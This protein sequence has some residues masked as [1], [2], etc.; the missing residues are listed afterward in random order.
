VLADGDFRAARLSTDLLD[1]RTASLAEDP[2][3]PLEALLAVAAADLLGVARDAAGRGSKDGA[4]PRSR[5]DPWTGLSG[6]R[7]TDEGVVP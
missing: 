4:G 2:P 1:T 3:V 7:L 5:P 6:W